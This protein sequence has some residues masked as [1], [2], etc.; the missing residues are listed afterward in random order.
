MMSKIQPTTNCSCLRDIIPPILL[1]RKKV[2]FG[3]TEGRRK[4]EYRIKVEKQEDRIIFGIRED[5]N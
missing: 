2:K 1:E 5:L 3:I 4:Q